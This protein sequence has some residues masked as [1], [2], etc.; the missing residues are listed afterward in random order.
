MTVHA[1]LLTNEVG[2]WSSRHTA[3]TAVPNLFLAG[4]Y[5][6]THI[7]LVCMEGAVSAGLYAAEAIRRYVG[8]PGTI[9]VRIPATRPRW[10]W[11]LA[12]F[13]L[14]PFAAAAKIVLIIAAPERMQSPTPQSVK[15]RSGAER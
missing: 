10:I 9:E 4:D 3:A 11:W 5:C 1:G 14:M 7:D 8:A 2:M 13:L 6:K 15:R 12:R